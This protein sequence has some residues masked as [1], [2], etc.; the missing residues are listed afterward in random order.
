MMKKAPTHGDVVDHGVLEV[1]SSDRRDPWSELR[2]PD[3]G[4]STENEVMVSRELGD[5][6]C[7]GEVEDVALGLNR[8]PES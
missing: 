6:L 8:L 4:M 1:I 5:C 7:G 2:V 3:K